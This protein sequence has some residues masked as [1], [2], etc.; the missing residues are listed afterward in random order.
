[1]NLDIHTKEMKEM[2]DEDEYRDHLNDK[3]IN[4]QQKDS[5]VLHPIEFA[6]NFNK[7]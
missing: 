3:S 2:F 4:S 7:Q 6:Y 1:M 5:E